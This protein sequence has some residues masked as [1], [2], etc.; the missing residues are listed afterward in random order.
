MQRLAAPMT[1]PLAAVLLAGLVIR[2]ALVNINGFG[3]DI[4]G[5]QE[6]TRQLVSAPLA[7]YYAA[8]MEVPPDHLPGDLW[9]LYALGHLWRW[10]GGGEVAGFGTAMI[11][12]K[13]VP[14]VVDLV[15]G[16]LALAL[17]RPLAG[18]RIARFTLLAIL[19]NPALVFVSAIWGQW[20]VLATA[21]SV[22]TVYALLRWGATGL[23]IGLPVLA[24]SALVKPQL[25]IL[26]LPM[27]VFAIRQ[28][29]SGA[30]VWLLIRDMTI[31]G[32]SSVML[33]L[34][35]IIPFDVGF[36]GMGMRW[37][38]IERAEFAASR[39]HLTTMGAYN[40]WKWTMPGGEIDDRGELALGL[41]YQQVG[42]VLFLLACV[43]ALLVAWRWPDARVG[44]LVG[45]AIMSTALFMVLTRS[46]SRYFVPG[47]VFVIIAAAVVPRMRAAAWV[48]TAGS[49]VNVWMGFGY[50]R[51][52]WVA[53]VDYPSWLLWLVA[54]V[55]MVA[56][57]LLLWNA[58]PQRQ[59]A[60]ASRMV[61][62]REV[63]ALYMNGSQENRT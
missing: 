31:G 25:L 10:L 1:W 53:G 56:F 8:D 21:L 47:L 38:I 23:V 42:L 62:S 29:R 45:C 14:I 41:S 13:L 61:P 39:F 40:L 16:V 55:N 30:S 27:T 35:A 49:L 54:S 6:W 43:Y 63:A 51:S 59:T 60:P 36:P 37:T 22:A 4:E 24:A 3:Y 48:L 58:W 34:A 5:F 46:H 44:M 28:W 11:A 33:A 2:L 9:V 7:S 19:L 18:D 26:L 57:G 50:R 20:N 32:V 52:E 17:V 15:L 12:I